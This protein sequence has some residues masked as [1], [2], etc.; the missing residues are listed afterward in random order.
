M[1]SVDKISTK[2]WK[3]IPYAGSSAAAG[4]I[5]WDNLD[6]DGLGTK[7]QR[8]YFKQSLR[9]LLEALI[10][11]SERDAGQ[12]SPG[13][14]RNKQRRLWA[15][16]SWMAKRELWR[17]S[18][19]EESDLIDYVQEMIDRRLSKKG[20]I[21]EKTIDSQISFFHDLWNL[22][23][24][25]SAPIRLDPD[26][27]KELLSL[28]AS[29][30][31]LERWAPV[32][33]EVAKPLI[34]DALTWMQTPAQLLN[35]VMTDVHQKIGG[36]VGLT[37]K[38]ISRRTSQVYR[39]IASTEDYVRLS[40]FLGSEQGDV[41]STLRRATKLTD[42]AVL[43][44][45]LFLTGVRISEARS[46]KLGCVTEERHD[47]G[48]VYRY[49]NGI[50]AKKKGSARHWVAP[51]AVVNAI[52]LLA[53]RFQLA[54]EG[55]E[56][57]YLFRSIAGN[58]ARARVSTRVTVP[59]FS[60]LRK[61]LLRFA[62]SLHRST[63]FYGHL[64]PHQGRKTFARFVMCRDKRALGALV[65]HYGHLHGAV[66]DGAYVGSDIELQEIL[67]DENRADL[68]QGLMDMLSGA[69]LGGKGAASLS[70]MRESVEAAA[71]FS[72]RTS[73]Q[74]IVDRMIEQ[75]VKLAPCDWGYCLYQEEVSACRGTASGPNPINRCPST[76]SSCQN[77]AVTDK[78]RPWWEER[79]RREEAFLQRP[80][81]PEQTRAVA[82]S[83]LNE[84]TLLLRTFHQIR[85]ERDV[86]EDQL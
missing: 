85:V 4:E 68:A 43:V 14:V 9:E 11:K 26:K 57:P 74:T 24:S 46:L 27:S 3:V 12:L 63:P 67:D 62:S 1:L 81:L 80:N 7:Y 42:G 15:L 48:S 47:T 45:V 6:F 17:L 64:H 33:L 40:Q 71:K 55:P 23:E 73:L 72:G 76:C 37:R 53:A 60:T 86:M 61:L 13:T 41:V 16:A 25:Y 44:L 10:V 52:D 49:I 8:E 28:K 36:T 34:Q 77:F 29:G 69:T 5:M 31:G 82:Q 21:R 38:Q 22:R 83:R 78:S 50:A 70:K 39:D 79:Y 20:S 65:Q 56:I 35:N 58:G 19:L 66:L 75:G 32:P 84:T 2:C 54:R 30:S 51:M 18:Q 59:S